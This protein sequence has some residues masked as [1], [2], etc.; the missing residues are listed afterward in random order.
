LQLKNKARY[1]KG[2]TDE[3]FFFEEG[4]ARTK[5]TIPKNFTGSSPGDDNS[6]LACFGGEIF[7]ET[8]LP[9]LT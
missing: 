3:N 6:I 4:V 1:K 2:V 8:L 7:V 5:A 9:F